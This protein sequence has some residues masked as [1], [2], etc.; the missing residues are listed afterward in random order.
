MGVV[1]GLFELLREG[2]EAAVEGGENRRQT[3]G[4]VAVELPHV[5]AGKTVVI[6]PRG[7]QFVQLGPP[8][9][10]R[11]AQLPEGIVHGVA[12]EVQQMACGRVPGGPLAGNGEALV[13]LFEPLDAA[14]QGRSCTEMAQGDIGETVSLIENVKGVARG[15]QDHPTA[16]GEVGHHQIVVGDD[17]VGVLQGG[18]GL[19]ETALIDLATAV[20]GALA[21]IHRQGPPAGLGDGIGPAVPVPV[22]IPGVECRAQVL[23]QGEGVA[24]RVE[25]DLV[26][27]QEH[28]RVPGARGVETLFQLDVA[29]V[30]ATALGEGEAVVPAGGGQ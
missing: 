19:E 29:Q 5:T 28:A 23:D 4:P 17:A 9:G 20:P 10:R 16:E 25:A 13:H 15:R 11:L 30:A 7:E 27:E 8:Q 1:E 18:A 12:G 6:R 22:P 24:I 3:L 14:L 26:L 21:A 2:G